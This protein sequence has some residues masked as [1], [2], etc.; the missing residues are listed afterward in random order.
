MER[1]VVDVGCNDY[2]VDR[3]EHIGQMSQGGIRVARSQA[4]LGPGRAK[5]AIGLFQAQAGP[6]AGVGPTLE[7]VDPGVGD[8][9]LRGAFPGQLD[10]PHGTLP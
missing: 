3:T 2:Q 6:L 1:L 9:R 4:D 10:H 8:G 7:R 5:A